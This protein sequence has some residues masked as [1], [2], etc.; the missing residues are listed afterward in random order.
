MCSLLFHSSPLIINFVQIPGSALNGIKSE[1]AARNPVE[2]ASNLLGLDD[3]I[4]GRSLDRFA[5]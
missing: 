2:N 4:R 5:K 1:L 3:G